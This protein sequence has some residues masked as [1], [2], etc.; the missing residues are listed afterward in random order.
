MLHES[1]FYH[2]FSL[3]ATMHHSEPDWTTHSHGITGRKRIVYL[4]YQVYPNKSSK[5]SYAFK[6]FYPLL[7]I[8]EILVQVQSTR[9]MLINSNS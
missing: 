6:S 9:M 7:A 8:E 2:R 3:A 4:G 5:N 1:M